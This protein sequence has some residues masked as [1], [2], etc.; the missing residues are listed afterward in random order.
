ML[1]NVSR[2]ELLATFLGVPLA[3]ATG[4]QRRSS[5][6]PGELVGASVGAGHRLRE[7]PPPSPS[8][9]EE[10]PVLIVG[11]GVA[12]LAAAWRL[13][14]AGFDR[15]LLCEIE[16]E[17][18]G[19]SRFGRKGVVPHPWGAHYLPAPMAENRDLLVLLREMGIVEGTDAEGQPIYAEQ[20]LCRDPQERLYAYG[21]WYDGLY[22]A[23]GATPEDQRQLRQFYREVDHWVGFRDG[24]GRK[25]F[26]LP[27]RRGSDDAV[28]TDL[29]RLSMSDWLDQRQLSSSRLRWVVD[30]GCR[31]DYGSRPEDTSAWA[32]LFYFASRRRAEGAEPQPLLSWPEGNGRLVSQLAQGLAHR[33]QP[34][35]AVADIHPTDEGLEVTVRSTQGE[36]LRGYRARRVIFAAPQFLT[37]HLIR[38]YRL[39]PPPHL[40]SFDYGSWMV[41]NLHLRDRPAETQGNLAWDNVL[42]DSPS[43]GYVV[44]THQAGIDHGPTILTYYY[45][46]TASNSLT[47]R[48]Q[49][50]QLGRDEWAELALADLERPHPDLRS[51]VTRIDVMRWG[52]AMIRP[53]PG[54]LWSGPRRAAQLPYRGIHFAH[55]DLSGVA[56]FEEAFDQGL[57]AAGDVMAALGHPVGSHPGITS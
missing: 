30:Y 45:P 3:L 14:R 34:D 15:F 53:R 24:Q 16:P 26:T 39:Q 54:F 56:L 11:G 52:H 28:V 8:T 41:A 21:H 19:T 13:R 36:Q 46:L 42:H 20:V 9:W 31:D 43:L 22:L 10:I 23:A 35:W 12:G 57:R 6:P 51:L 49:L 29:D 7:G 2:R 40:T 47:A 17:V 18:G 44:A 55:S 33:L 38:P 1:S 32:G 27:T 48:N 25:A 4:C 37:R 5:L 50:L